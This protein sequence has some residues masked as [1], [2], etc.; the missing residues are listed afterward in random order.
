[1]HLHNSLQLANALQQ[2]GKQFELMVY[3]GSRHGVTNRKQ[4]RHLYEMM[5]EFV[6]REL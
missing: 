1:M 5:T 2:A 4:R 3:P 6:T